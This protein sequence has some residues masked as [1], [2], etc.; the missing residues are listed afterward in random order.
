VAVSLGEQAAVSVVITTYDEDPRFLREAIESVLA[1]T[2]AARE[3]I[4]VDDGSRVDNSSVLQPFPTVRRIRQDNQGL[5]TARNTGWRAAA[6]PYVVF[7]DSDDRLTPD[8]LACNLRRFA[9]APDCALVYGAYRFIDREGRRL[10]DAAFSPIG[11]DPYATML[12]GNSIGMHA[13]VMYRRDRLEAVGGF[14]PAY[15]ACEDYELYLRLSRRFPIASGVEVMAEYRQ[16]ARNMSNN[17]PLMLKTALA[18]LASQA[19]LLGDDRERQLAYA[20]GVRRW[21]S[22]YAGQQLLKMY[23]A[24][25][26][27]RWAD[28]SVANFLSVFLAAPLA[29]LGAVLHGIRTLLPRRTVNL[30][31]LRRT[32]PIS[33]HFGYDRGKPVDR[34]Y[35]EAFLARHAGDIRGRVL[36]VG[37]N[38]YTRG[39]GGD[40]V[41]TSDVLHV[42]PAARGATLVGDLQKGDNLPSNAFD[43][44]VLTQTLHLLFDMRAAVATLHRILKPGGILLVT[45]PGVSSVDSGEWGGTWMWSLTEASLGRLL[46]GSFA[47]NDVA[48]TTYG[49]VLT[50]VAFLHGLAEDELRPQEYDVTDPHYPVIVAGRA[51][52]TENARPAA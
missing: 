26:D 28:V 20:E 46:A 38:D 22:F 16:H 43:C 23:E 33:R 51:K 50:A 8:A 3:I 2:V 17:S 47:E 52:K 14:D 29:M 45:V 19:Q 34:H 40:R 21:K 32:T 49:N 7:L 35:I 48:A 36:E 5:A 18:A 42:D 12:R 24:A 11:P 13:T 15:R 1:Q 41:T 4:V 31:S 25:K 10:S 9:A 44:V 39:L 6:G 27:R 37:D 30:G